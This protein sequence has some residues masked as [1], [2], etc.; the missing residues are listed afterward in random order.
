MAREGSFPLTY[1]CVDV[2]GRG[3]AHKEDQ[4][5]LPHMGLEGPEVANKRCLGQSSLPYWSA[6]MASNKVQPSEISVS[7][8]IA[9]WLWTALT[10][11]GSMEQ[12]ERTWQ[13]VEELNQRGISLSIKKVKAHT[14]DDELASLPLGLGNKFA[15]HHAG[16]AV[17]QFPAR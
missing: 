6:S 9:R 13:L 5:K 1:V 16:L 2:D 12:Y 8:P 4:T 15:D 17:A 14:D 11:A 3:F 7:A 10:K